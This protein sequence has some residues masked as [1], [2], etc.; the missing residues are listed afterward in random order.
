MGG[1]PMST[2][3]RRRSSSSANGPGAN[4]SIVTTV[5]PAAS[6]AART[7]DGRRGAVPE[8]RR[9]RRGGCRL[10]ERDDLA[11][12]RVVRRG[13]GR[14]GQLGRAG[15]HGRAGGEEMACHRLARRGRGHAGR[16]AAGG[17]RG[18]R[19]ARPL[20]A[21]RGDD[22]ED[23]A[24]REA[25]RREAGGDL[26]DPCGEDAVRDHRDGRLAH[27]WD[28]AAATD[29]IWARMQPAAWAHLVDER[30]WTAE[31]FSERTVAG[32]LAECVRAP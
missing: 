28:A 4:R 25:A 21:V 2:D 14:A 16:G 12:A 9:E 13:P 29:W 17:H 8:A 26:G 3:T 15:Q 19:D 24:R 6:P 7:T 32:L 1:A 20:R 30:G 11:H 10:A 27:G 22:G 31:A 23:V 5:A 18:E